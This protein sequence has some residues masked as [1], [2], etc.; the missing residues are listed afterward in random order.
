[1][2]S[3]SI[4][5]PRVNISTLVSCTGSNK[6]KVRASIFT[7]VDPIV[8]VG[9]NNILGMKGR[10][11]A[12]GLLSMSGGCVSVGDVD[13][14]ILSLGF[15]FLSKSFLVQI[16]LLTCLLACLRIFYLG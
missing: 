12:W 10:I 6:E 8:D 13:G 3:Y 11:H 1:M 7:H 5:C 4:Y 16:F 9:L 2:R 14:V 15:S